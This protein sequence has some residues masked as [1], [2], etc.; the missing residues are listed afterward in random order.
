MTCK[1]SQQFGCSWKGGMCMTVCMFERMWVFGFFV[2]SCVWP[3]GD[4]NGCEC[5]CVGLNTVLI[6]L[7]LGI[8]KKGTSWKLQLIRSK[9]IWRPSL[10]SQTWQ[11]P[12]A[13]LADL[14]LQWWPSAKCTP[15]SRQ[16]HSASLSNQNDEDL[17]R[18][19]WHIVSSSSVCSQYF[20]FY[21]IRILRLQFGMKA[22]Y[23]LMKWKKKPK[24]IIYTQVCHKMP[25]IACTVHT[26]KISRLTKQIIQLIPL[27]MKNTHI[28]LFSYIAITKTGSF[29]KFCSF[30]LWLVF[31]TLACWDMSQV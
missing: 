18:R 13:P 23:L 31:S 20:P 7:V 4:W 19:R 17:W 9:C 5:V 14:Y 10:F 1:A 2:R 24:L 28:L 6:W 21:L 3:Q 12:S 26:V 29:F 30:S 15:S 27:S 22:N 16:A 25:V 8:L 11:E